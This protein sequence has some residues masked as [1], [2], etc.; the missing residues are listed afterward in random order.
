MDVPLK[1]QRLMI[2]LQEALPLDAM[3][4]VEIGNAMS[5]A[6]HYLKVAKPNSFYHSMGL[7]PMGYGATACIGAKLVSPERP[8]ISLCGD[9]AFLMNGTELHTAC[10]YGIPI[11]WIIENNG[12]HGMIYH[13][14]K[15][16]FG[17]RFH[18]SLFHQDVNYCKL[19]ES[20]GA[21]AYRI[22]K[23]GELGPVLARALAAKK[24]VLIDA[25]IDMNEAP[26]IG[27]RFKA[28]NR[29][30]HDKPL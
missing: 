11:V 20:L 13:G 29:Y 6:F 27:S 15:A 5:W 28:L 9:A 24:P 26:P 22:S 12:G 21:E 16:Q 17:G 1:P 25:R 3:V 7:G 2:E 8:V 19:A 10:E 14:E 30:F 18:N 4:F 23:P